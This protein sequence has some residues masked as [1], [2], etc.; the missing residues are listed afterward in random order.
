MTIYRGD[1]G[2][3][4]KKELPSS[5]LGEP[6]TIPRRR[7]HR[8][9]RRARGP[10]VRQRTTR[11]ARGRRKNGTT[12]LKPL[13]ERKTSARYDARRRARATAAGEARR[14]S[15]PR[16]R[17]PLLAAASWQPR[18]SR[19]SSPQ[20]RDRSGAGRGDKRARDDARRRAC[21][22][23]VQAARRSPRTTARFVSCSSGSIATAWGGRPSPPTPREEGRTRARRTT[24]P[25]LAELQK[26]A[27]IA[28]SPPTNIPPR[29][30]S[31]TTSSP[32]EQTLRQRVAMAAPAHGAMAEERR[33]KEISPPQ[34]Q[35][36]PKQ[37][38]ADLG[39]SRR[40]PEEATASSSGV[41]LSSGADPATKAKRPKR[42]RQQVRATTMK[43]KWGVVPPGNKPRRT[44][45]DNKGCRCWAIK[46][47]DIKGCGAGR[48]DGDRKFKGY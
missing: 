34:P 15:A 11:C 25:P 47:P 23:A 35:P 28:S 7:E 39:H 6:N 37:H 42:P 21:A 26:A 40:H 5:G 14:P 18:G 3:P 32:Y 33:A 9:R 46:M 12:T 38:H 30:P 1:D 2:A 45:G 43:E 22:P 10:R 24:T 13:H 27:S 29:V 44:D 36:S 41:S 16:P 31:R 48:R 19:T 17:Q 20:H 4:R 8:G